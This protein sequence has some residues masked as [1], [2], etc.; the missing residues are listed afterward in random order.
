MQL[1]S[2]RQVHT[3]FW[4]QP[5]VVRL[6][7]I[8]PLIGQKSTVSVISLE[9]VETEH[10]VAV[11]LAMLLGLQMKLRFTLGHDIMAASTLT[12][13]KMHSFGWAGMSQDNSWKA[14]LRN[15]ARSG[16]IIFPITTIHR[17]HQSHKCNVIRRTKSVEY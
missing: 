14:G 10:R 4:P 17:S 12:I 13:L 7:F 11:G 1:H 5:V 15:M 3:S 8:L 9:G 16:M 2:T 6:R